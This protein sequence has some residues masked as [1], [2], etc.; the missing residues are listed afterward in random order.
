MFR[1][2]HNDNANDDYNMM[3]DKLEVGRVCCHILTGAIVKYVKRAA[4]SDDDDDDNSAKTVIILLLNYTF[5]EL[6][7]GVLTGYIDR[8][9]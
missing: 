5:L 8:C 9:S 1:K 7:A 3:K 2:K 6:E 4:R